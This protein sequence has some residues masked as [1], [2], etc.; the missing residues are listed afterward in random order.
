[1]IIWQDAELTIALQIE[2]MRIKKGWTA[3]GINRIG[4]SKISFLEK[5]FNNVTNLINL[6]DS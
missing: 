6:Y 3:K 2:K 5:I 4:N 1:M